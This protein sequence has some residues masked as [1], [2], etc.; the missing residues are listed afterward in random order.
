MMRRIEVPQSFSSSL[1]KFLRVP[2]SNKTDVLKEL[3]TLK[4]NLSDKLN[5]Q[6]HKRAIAAAL[7][8]CGGVPKI[9]LPTEYKAAG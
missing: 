4:N 5:I 3:S 7:D 8:W 2:D 9:M 1:E 6:K